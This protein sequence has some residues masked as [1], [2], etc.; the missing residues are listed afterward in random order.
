MRL[1][2]VVLV[3]VRHLLLVGNYF[4][5]LKPNYI[6]R[7]ITYLGSK[8]IFG[9]CYLGFSGMRKPGKYLPWY[10][11]ENSE[12]QIYKKGESERRKEIDNTL[13]SAGSALN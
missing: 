3:K 12:K 11:S 4:Y 2:K 6:L 10:F 9:K 7:A 5:I 1:C 8:V 13:S